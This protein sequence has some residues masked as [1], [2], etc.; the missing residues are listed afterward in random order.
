L[1][2]CCVAL[3]AQDAEAD[4]IITLDDKLRRAAAALGFA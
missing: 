4:T 3:A 2:D 1:P